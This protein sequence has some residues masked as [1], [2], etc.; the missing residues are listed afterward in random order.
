[1][2]DCKLICERFFAATRQ[3]FFDGDLEQ[4]TDGDDTPHDSDCA[5]KPLQKA[6]ATR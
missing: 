1:M 5:H 6:S 4:A 2:T 3:H